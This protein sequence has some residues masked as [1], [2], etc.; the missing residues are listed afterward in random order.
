[1]N[2]VEQIERAAGSKRR[3]AALVGRPLAGRNLLLQLAFDSGYKAR[4]KRAGSGEPLAEAEAQQSA[5]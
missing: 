4:V 3:L 5:F 1:L 2:N